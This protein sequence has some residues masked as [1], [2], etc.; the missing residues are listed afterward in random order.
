MKTTRR[1][2]LR[3]VPTFLAVAAVIA[4]LGGGPG[5]K[6][7][8]FQPIDDPDAG[9]GGTSVFGI[10]SAGTMA[11]NYAD[12]DGVVHG[13]VL[14]GGQF[15]NV[16]VPNSFYS[17]LA[18]INSQGTAVGD[19]VD[20]QGLDRGFTYSSDGTI[21]YLPLAAPGATTIPIGI[22]NPGA[23]TGPYST[24][25]GATFHG[26]IYYKGSFTY[27]DPPG[28]TFT[29]PWAISNAG[30]VG[31]WYSDSSGDSHGFLRDRNGAFTQFDV[32]AQPLPRST[33]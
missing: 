18:H 5:S 9:P 13:F 6:G 23:V 29:V 27:F 11:G 28:S 30:T 2:L 20:D 24:D 21:T 10:N 25:N 32:Q 17:E 1:S 22:N 3:V 33:A 31:G 7:Y 19:F 14:I 16:T 8:K 26:F 12:A 4:G 15:T